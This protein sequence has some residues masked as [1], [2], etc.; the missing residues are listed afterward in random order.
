MDGSNSETLLTLPV[1]YTICREM[2]VDAA[3]GKVYLSLYDPAGYQQRAIASMNLDG[4]G[5]KIL[6]EISGSEPQEVTGGISLWANK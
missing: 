4:S 1:P 6:F 2:A 3:R 5:F